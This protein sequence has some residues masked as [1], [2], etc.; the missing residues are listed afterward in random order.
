MKTLHLHPSR[1][2]R[3]RIF[4]SFCPKPPHSKGL[5]QNSLTLTRTLLRS[6]LR[7][8]GTHAETST[9][10]L[11]LFVRFEVTVTFV[12]ERDGEHSKEITSRHSGERRRKWS[13]R[14]VTRRKE[15]WS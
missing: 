6:R 14:S 2:L 5:K 8:K 7:E 9:H 11:S 10:T 4:L 1:I 12:W 13:N 15:N 3:A